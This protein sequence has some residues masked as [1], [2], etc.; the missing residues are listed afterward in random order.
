MFL[1]HATKYSN[2]E[3]IFD[4]GA[5]KTGSE[6]LI[7]FTTQEAHSVN[8]VDLTNN[9]YGEDIVSFRIDAS[10]LDQSKV[11]D[12]IDHEPSGL[13][14]GIT[15]KTYSDDI[16]IEHFD[17]DNIMKYKSKYPERK[18]LQKAMKKRRNK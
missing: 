9:I 14:K 8:W 1:Y 13:F 6:G 15:V 10:N 2:Y 16:P 12:G 7:Y 17:L 5:I 11:E 4:D 3:K 18:E